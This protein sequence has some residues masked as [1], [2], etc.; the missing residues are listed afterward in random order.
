MPG[1]LKGLLVVAG[2]VLVGVVLRLTVFRPDPVPVTVHRVARGTVE[3]TVTNSKAGTVKARRRSKISP[4]IGGRVA[5]IGARPGDHV[6][7]GQ[8]MLRI[9]DKDLKATLALARQD[10]ATARSAS[11]EACLAADLAERDYR[12]SLALKGQN[13]VSEADIDRL[14]SHSESAAARCDAAK[15]GVE[16]A[17]AAVDLAQA[18]LN[19]T[20]LLAPFDGVIADLRTEVGEWASPSPPG[21]PLPPV[22]DLI[23]PTSIYVSAPLD[24]V[25]AGRV[26]KGLPARVTLDPYPGKSFDGTVTRVAPYVLDVE[27]QN[28]TLEVEVDFKDTAFAGTLLPGTSADVEIILR[29]AENVLRIPAYALLEGNRVLVYENGLLFGRQVKTGLRNWEWGEVTEGLK[30]GDTVVVSLDR[31]EVKEGARA[32]IESEQAGPQK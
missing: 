26:S 20:V 8:V 15:A 16:R 11:R 31:A 3:E 14:K 24:E 18:N 22:Y 2:L 13:L 23:D 9:N 21:I 29:K 5:F 10:L 27:Q 32:R 12:R 28:R 6:H 1:W 30:E 25:D 4:E 17:Q 19:K 7:K